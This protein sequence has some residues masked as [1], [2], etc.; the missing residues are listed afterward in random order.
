VTSLLLATLLMGIGLYGALTRRDI[1][2]G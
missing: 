1:V 2:A